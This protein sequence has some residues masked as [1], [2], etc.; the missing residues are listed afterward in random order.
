MIAV[1]VSALGALATACPHGGEYMQA[2]RSA[3]N[4]DRGE[5]NGRRF[6]FV[7]NKPEGDD[8]NIQIRGTSLFASY[9][10]EDS[11]DKLGG[12]IN[13]TQQESNKLWKLI[14]ALDLENRKKGKQDA[15][16][17]YVTLRL[18]EPG[19]N[20]TQQDVYTVYVARD[21]ADDDVI[22]LADYLRRLILKYK[23]EKPNF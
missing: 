23:N 17:G 18:H 7:S 20:D 2:D 14:D 1:A 15:E 22:A 8:W 5:T 9:A 4:I 11:V 12:A 19:A 21:T 3:A 16:I 10:R 13:I 6:D